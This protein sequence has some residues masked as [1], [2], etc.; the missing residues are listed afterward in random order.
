MSKP[1]AVYGAT[2]Y[3]GKLIVAELRRRGVEDVILSGR[4]AD[5]LREVAEANG[6]S[7]DV[8]RAAAFDDA[9]ALRAALDGSGAVI[10]AAGPFSTVGGGV[11]TA[12]IEAGCHYV[13]TTGEQP[14][15]RRVIDIHGDAA[16]RAGVALVSG[17]GFDYLPGDLICAIAAEGMPAVDELTIAYN[18]K[19][20]GAT[21]GTMR[22]ALLMMAGGDV[23]YENHG[24]RQAGWRQPLR[25]T[26][27][28]GPGIGAQPVSRYPSG[29]VITVP[30]HVPVRTVRSRITT[31]TIAPDPRAAPILPFITPVFGVL[32]RTPLRT[33]LH[34][35]IGRLPEGPSLEER[36]A[37]AYTLVAEASGGGT[38]RR[39]TLHGSDIY[40]ITAVTTVE[41]ALRMTADGYDRAGGLAPAEAY[42]PR[43]FLDALAEHGISYDAPAP[44]ATTTTV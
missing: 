33:V 19:G 13:D 10:A 37:V 43:S 41:G 44:A 35:A 17:M 42:E 7:A 12:A 26:F 14:F 4:R 23:V 39:A 9:R 31:A 1:I 27:D 21:R 5:A 34:N 11:V 30:R 22:S 38:T 36:R 25:E 6:Y 3:T 16:R 18:V 32:L 2:G 24:F 20:F 28:F 15:I 40:G 29:E 8:V